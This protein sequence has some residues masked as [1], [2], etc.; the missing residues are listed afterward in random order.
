MK[1]IPSI[2]DLWFIVFLSLSVGGSKSLNFD[3]QTS[4]LVD[5][6][7]YGCLLI[8]RKK[9]AFVTF[10]WLDEIVGTMLIRFSV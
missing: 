1:C 2:L 7:G 9:S 8:N 5:F 3:Y 4:G 6:I 10:Q